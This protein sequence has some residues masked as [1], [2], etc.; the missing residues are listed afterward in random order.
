MFGFL[1]DDEAAGADGLACFDDGSAIDNAV[2][3]AD[4]GSHVLREVSLGVLPA[5]ILLLH[6]IAS[7]RAHTHT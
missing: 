4:A 5:L 7:M 1:Y 3:V 6:H 2:P